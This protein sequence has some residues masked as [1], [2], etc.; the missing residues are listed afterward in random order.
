MIQLHGYQHELKSG[1]YQSWNQGASNALAV[2]P[3]GGGK[4]IVIS[5]IVLDKVRQGQSGVI[6]AHRNELVSQMSMHIARRGIPHRIIGPDNMIRAIAADHRLEFG[7]RSFVDQGAITAVGGVDTIKARAESLE[8]WAHQQDYWITDEAHHVLRRNKWGT[9]AGMFINAHGLGVTASPARADGA[10]LG[11]HADGLFDNMIVGPSMRDLIDMGFLSD[12]EIA[13]PEA[14][15][16]MDDN[17]IGASGD[18][19][20]NKMRTKARNSQIVGDVVD[21]Y[22]KFAFGKRA[23][24]FATDVET[25]LKI[26]ARFNDRGIAAAAVSAE[27]HAEVRADIIKRFRD[28]RL[29]LL[30][31]VDLFGEGFDVPACEVVI[32]AR[33]TASLAVYLQQFG[34]AL[35]VFAGK[36]YGLVIDHVENWKHHSYPDMPRQWT[37]DRREKRA[38]KEKDPEEM[39]LMRC[40]GPE[41]GKLYITFFPQ[42]PY[43]GH[44]PVPEVRDGPAQ[45][46]GNLILLDRAKLDE[47]R[48]EI[49]LESAADVGAR[50]GAVAGGLAAAGTINKQIEKIAAQSRLRAAIEQWAGI[51]RHKGRSD[52]ESYKRFYYATGV[53]VLTALAKHNK[54][55]DFDALAD[56]VEGWVWN[57]S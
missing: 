29:T 41:C 44:R 21:N 10:G 12:Y 47:M 46:E 13:V 16:I 19:S 4:S 56:K 34:R 22:V 51:Q 5:D 8:S 30:V 57:A 52:E 7:G 39:P 49:M 15:F 11:S 1:V 27:T 53:D 50:V 24:C 2:L 48:R 40:K 9:V 18:Y 31:N 23:I 37:L 6:K 35:R 28:G 14:S 20:P 36:T 54:R 55:A 26:A 45:V 25:S 38:K 42:C 32:M 3:T 43:C 33:P 17:D